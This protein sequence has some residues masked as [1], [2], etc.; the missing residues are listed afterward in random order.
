MYKDLVI[1][2]VYNEENT[3][4]E[5]CLLLKEAYTGDVLFVDDGSTDSSKAFLDGLKDER[6]FYIRHSHRAGY[7]AALLSGFKFSLDGGYSRT[8]TLDVDLQHDPARIPE[9][10]EG[11]YGAELV[12]GSRYI[13]FD[14]YLDV[15]MDRLVINRYIA[16]LI[17][18]M[19]SV[20]ITDPFCGYRGYRNDFLKK[21]TL[22]D[23]G[24]RMALEVLLEAVRVNATFL[25]IPVEVVYL[26]RM[27]KFLDGLDDP[28]KRLRYYIEIIER[29]RTEIENEKKVLNSEPAS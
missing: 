7:G 3:L 29:K 28:H 12:L 19:F 15:P 6:A 26:D 21:I 4:E 13:K 14:K 17:N 24:Y 8:V 10:F 23:K 27:R 18:M 1:C 9:F 22:H 20:K 5:F 16:N 2:P 25:E 11:L